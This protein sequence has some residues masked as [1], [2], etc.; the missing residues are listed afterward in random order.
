MKNGVGFL[1]VGGIFFS[2]FV[3]VNSL[4]LTGTDEVAFSNNGTCFDHSPNFS[5][6]EISGNKI[7]TFY[8]DLYGIITQVGCYY[9]V[10]GDG[11]MQATELC[12]PEGYD[13][14]YANSTYPGVC[15]PSSDSCFKA[16][17]Y[18]KGK[19]GCLSAN[20][21]VANNSLDPEDIPP[22]PTIWHPV[23][24]CSTK[25]LDMFTPV[26]VWNEFAEECRAE[27]NWLRNFYGSSCCIPYQ[28]RCEFRA[29]YSS[30]I[31]N[32]DN[33]GQN[34][35]IDFTAWEWNSSLG[36]EGDWQVPR[37]SSTWCQNMTKA[38]ECSAS[39][40]LPSFE[41]L[42]FVISVLGIGIVYFLFGKKE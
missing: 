23:Y 6:F 40:R 27:A 7:Y 11:V 36:T 28:D 25:C 15:I 20:E 35:T 39:I 38:F 41:F 5:Y 34:I 31:D 22:F 26:C 24:G 17:A 21:S 30:Q 42:N 18:G 33:P 8:T 10:N 37:V 13:C 29:N 32:C 3:F 16:G 2:M 1:L 4:S 14:A 12:C 19:S 9:D